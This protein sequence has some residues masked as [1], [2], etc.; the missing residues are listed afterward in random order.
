MRGKKQSIRGSVK[1]DSEVV[2][3]VEFV[4]VEQKQHHVGSL[5]KPVNRRE[6]LEI[7]KSQQQKKGKMERKKKYIPVDD[8]CEVVL[9]AFLLLLPAQNPCGKNIQQKE[10]IKTTQKNVIGKIRFD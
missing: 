6:E 5:G 8:S 9:S 10:K 3:N 1:P 2:R 7:E 4:G